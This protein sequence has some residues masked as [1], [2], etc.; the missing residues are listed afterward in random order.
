MAERIVL[1][2]DGGSASGA[3]LEWVVDRSRM[4]PVEVR[5]TTVMELAWA[6][7]ALPEDTYRE[8]Y[9]RILT[10][11]IERLADGAPS[12]P[13]TG[14]LLFGDP[15][16]GLVSASRDADLVVIG[17]NRSGA[18]AGFTYG[19]L[20]L[21]LAA[22][23]QCPLVVV[24]ADWNASAGSVVVG[25]DGHKTGT[26]ALFLAAAEAE[27]RDA[28]LRVLHCWNMPRHI[29]FGYDLEPPFSRV[30][31]ENEA[32]LARAVTAVRE[33]Y[34]EL[35][36][37][38]SLEQSPPPEALVE[39]GRSAG[40]VVVGTHGRGPVGGLILGSVSHDVLLGMPCPVAVVPPAER[41]P[42]PMPER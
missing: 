9:E 16:H 10:D 21:R 35:E 39:A 3:A 15:L 38:G 1:A 22:H 8:S 17:S 31:E 20:P 34:P 41:V 30:L 2:A 13:A 32:I 23:V 28:P 33:S 25:V 12:A 40:L 24:P 36:V 37:T 5:V 7:A 18:L 4:V 29:G 19:T 11:A 6:P 26:A 27:R 14:E 42:T